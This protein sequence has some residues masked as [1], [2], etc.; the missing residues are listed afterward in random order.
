[1]GAGPDTEQFTTTGWPWRQG[2]T[3]RLLDE[4]GSY[5]APMLANPIG[6][7]MLGVAAGLLV[8]GNIVIRR[9]T[10]IA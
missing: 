2:N 7:V 6:W 9:M 5:F 3:F 4:G 10:A 8:I 1:M